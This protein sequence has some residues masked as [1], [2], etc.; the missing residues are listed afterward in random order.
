MKNVRITFDDKEIFESYDDFTDVQ[1]TEDF[2]TLLE[3]IKEIVINP[4][5]A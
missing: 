5:E 4:S 2:L 1:S 3:Q